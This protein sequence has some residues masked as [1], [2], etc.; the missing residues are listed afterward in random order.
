M[1]SSYPSFDFR[2][3]V[4]DGDRDVSRC[5]YRNASK[6]KGGEAPNQRRPDVVNEKATTDSLPAERRETER[7]RDDRGGR[8]VAAEDAGGGGNRTETG[9]VA[10]SLL[11]PGYGASCG[12]RNESF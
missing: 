1:I 3:P 12:I 7:K 2:I 6:K 9:P 8:R 11:L 4:V 5:R 10:G